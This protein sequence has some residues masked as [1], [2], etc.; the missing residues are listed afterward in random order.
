MHLHLHIQGSK[1][2]LFL[3]PFHTNYDFRGILLVNKNLFLHAFLHNTVMTSNLFYRCA[4]F[5]NYDKL[6]SH[7]QV[8]WLFMLTIAL[9]TVCYEYS[10]KDQRAQKHVERS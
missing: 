10:E 8:V 2:F 4:Q 7:K 3:W 9:D 5:V 1:T 6:T